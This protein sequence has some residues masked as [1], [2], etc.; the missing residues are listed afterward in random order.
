M[1]NDVKY[2]RVKSNLQLEKEYKSSYRY[3]MK[4]KF[5]AAL[6]VNCR[7]SVYGLFGLF[8]ADLKMRN[9]FFLNAPRQEIS[10]MVYLV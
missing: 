4:S 7:G 3:G 8:F 5:R 6:K 9:S 2:W 10:S 1:L